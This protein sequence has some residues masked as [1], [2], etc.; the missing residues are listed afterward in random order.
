MKLITMLHI[1]CFILFFSC[2]P[3]SNST[4]QTTEQQTPQQTQPETQSS[5]DTLPKTVIATYEAAVVYAGATDFVFKTENGEQL[6]IRESNL[7]EEQTIEMPDNMVTSS[8]DDEEGFPDANPELVG[9]KF[10]IMYN[11]KGQIYKIQL[12]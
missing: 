4:S 7:E 3:T 8:D 12:D 1:C 2:E 5:T 6:M 10:E 11:K 9:K